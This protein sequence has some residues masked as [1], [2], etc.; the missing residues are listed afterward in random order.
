MIFLRFARLL[1]ALSVVMFGYWSLLK[2]MG[3]GPVWYQVAA[4]VE[5]CHKYWW[6]N[7]LFIN[8]LVPWNNNF[9]NECMGWTWYLSVDTLLFYFVPPLIFLYTRSTKAGFALP[10]TLI[11]SSIIAAGFTA[12]HNRLS[13][14]PFDPNGSG[15]DYGDQYYTKFWFRAPPYLT[16]VVAALFL[17]SYGAKGPHRRPPAMVSLFALTVA[18][19]LLGWTTFGGF[20]MYRTIL[21]TWNR[22]QMS[23]WVAI[24]RPLWGLGLC[25]LCL[26]CHFGHAGPIGYLLASPIWPPLSRLTFSAYLVH[27]V[28]I[29]GV[30]YS[31]DHPYTYSAI[32]AAILTTGIGTLSYCCAA[33]VFL[34]VE[35]PFANLVKLITPNPKGKR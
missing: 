33:L 29:S 34:F 28:V 23:V 18:C 24:S 30:Y 22:W 1:P 13:M 26:V 4:S 17:Q 6:T 5:P 9:S 10:L 20:S 19:V 32:N 27:E 16:G 7:L 14:Y 12:W 3:S 2:Y 31:Q 35:S 11:A 15:G 25:L 8:T 21:G